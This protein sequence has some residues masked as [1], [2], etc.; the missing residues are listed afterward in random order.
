MRVTIMKEAIFAA[1]LIISVMLC[2]NICRAEEYPGFAVDTDELYDSLGLSDENIYD[3]LPP[4]A[5]GFLDDSGISLTDAGRMTEI[6][7]A[8]VFGYIMER[9]RRGLTGPV[10][11]LGMMTA[12][13]ALSA[14][15]AG[16]SEASPDSRINS[17]YELISVLVTTS[18]IAAPISSCLAEITAAI[19][20]GGNFMLTYI[21]IFAGIAASSG[22]VTA[23]AAYD[24]SLEAAAGGAVQLSAHLILPLLSV[25]MAV[26]MIDGINP[27]FSLGAFTALINKAVSFT[28]V[29]VLTVFSGILSLQSTIGTAADTVGIKTAKLAVANFVPVIGGALSDTYAAVRSGLSVLK[30]AAGFFGIAAVA[31]TVLPPLISSVS[32]YIALNIGAAAAEILSQSRMSKL[33][34]NSAGVVGTAM[35]ILICFAALLIIST[36]VIMSQRPA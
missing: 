3:E 36:A 34:K 23:A 2:G 5:A 16:L 10:R 8:E 22:T 12:A 6:S 20:S 17:T 19:T 11:L 15:V 33:L 31:A 9:F 4:E 27:Q 30:N 7:P 24:L 29:T 26:G 13:A 35:S 1:V 32:L 18:V 21:P 25:C 28:M 14:A